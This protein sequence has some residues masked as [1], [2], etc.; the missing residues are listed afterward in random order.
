[1]ASQLN[2]KVHLDELTSSYA[3]K[4]LIVEYKNG[5]NE[6]VNEEEDSFCVG[7]VPLS[8]IDLGQRGESP[9]LALPLIDL[10]QEASLPCG[11]N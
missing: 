9:A 11:R 2:P 6:T 4:E 3:L 8:V 1:M 5:V 7:M 10:G